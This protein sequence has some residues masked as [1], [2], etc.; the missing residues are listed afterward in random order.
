MIK[1]SNEIQELK[2]NWLSDPC[3]DI[4]KTKGFERYF[5]ELLEFRIKKEKEWKLQIEKEQRKFADQ[6]GTSSLKLA[7]YIYQLENRIKQL[8]KQIRT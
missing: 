3:W 1:S 6:L 4:E 8:E 7:N 5:D 2:N